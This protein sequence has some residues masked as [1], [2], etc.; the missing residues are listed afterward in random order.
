MA[1]EK[2]TYR[3]NHLKIIDFERV[4]KIN[5]Y[6]IKQNQNALN[7][8]FDNVRIAQLAAWR[9]KNNKTQSIATL[10]K[11]RR[12]SLLAQWQKKHEI[13]NRDTTSDDF[14]NRRREQLNNWRLNKTVDQTTN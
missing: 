7:R 6:H 2:I 9:K 10:A 13:N 12:A 11:M 4:K 1:L 5:K 8:P 14:E 3:K